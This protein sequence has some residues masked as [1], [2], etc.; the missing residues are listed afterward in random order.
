MPTYVALS[1]EF[2]LSHSMVSANECSGI[3]RK[4]LISL[5][6]F[7]SPV[8]SVYKSATF[9]FF[10]FSLSLDILSNRFLDELYLSKYNRLSSANPGKSYTDFWRVYPS[11]LL[12][13]D[14]EQSRG[15]IFITDSPFVPETAFVPSKSDVISSISI[16]S[17]IRELQKFK[18]STFTS[19]A[20]CEI[21]CFSC[22][23]E[24]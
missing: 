15:F 17:D 4:L 12:F 1:A 10:S 21:S 3:S 9:R 8:N 18:L 13:N 19:F 2:G 23:V 14:D 16:K 22:N 7:L 20:I 24:Y 11:L 5:G 6:G